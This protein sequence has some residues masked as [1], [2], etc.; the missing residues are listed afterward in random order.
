MPCDLTLERIKKLMAGRG[1][2]HNF[3]MKTSP[4]GYPG[5]SSSGVVSATKGKVC[6]Q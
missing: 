5:K 2:R 6:R 1:S 4:E 3:S